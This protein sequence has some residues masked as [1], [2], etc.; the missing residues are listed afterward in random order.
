MWQCLKC[1]CMCCSLTLKWR[2]VQA[3]EICDMKLKCIFE[4][5]RGDVNN[6]NAN[7]T[8]MSNN[9]MHAHDS[10]TSASLLSVNSS[11]SL[12]AAYVD[13]ADTLR[14]RGVSRKANEQREETLQRSDASATLVN[15]SRTDSLPERGSFLKAA[16]TALCQHPFVP[17]LLYTAV[18]VFLGVLI[19]KLF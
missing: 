10:A 18:C 8:G 17:L 12:V 14:Q 15:S 4:Q 16:N 7:A 19:G 9:G 3:R 13:S 6:L 2:D 1:I 11:N 5:A